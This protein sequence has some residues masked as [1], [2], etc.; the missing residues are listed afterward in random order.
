MQQKI[1]YSETL[2]LAELMRGI[3][4]CPGNRRV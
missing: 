1:L 3:K 2:W 4:A